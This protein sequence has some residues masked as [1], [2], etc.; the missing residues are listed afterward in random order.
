MRAVDI[1]TGTQDILLADTEL[2]IENSFRMVV[3][4]PTMIAHRKIKEAT[5]AGKDIAISGVMMGGG[6]NFW[7]AKDHLNAGYKIYSTKEKI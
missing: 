1:D 3:P 5:N 4:S 7:A 6:P 2:D